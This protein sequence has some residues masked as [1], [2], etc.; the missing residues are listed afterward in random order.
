MRN[1]SELQAGSMLVDN[2]TLQNLCTQST[3][4]MFHELE[5]LTTP[6]TL[7][8]K[9]INK[10]TK[11]WKATLRVQA[12]VCY[13]RY[14][15]KPLTLVYQYLHLSSMSEL[16]RGRN[17]VTVDVRREEAF[18]NTTFGWK[19]ELNANEHPAAWQMKN[20]QRFFLFTVDTSAAVLLFHFI[21]SESAPQN[22]SLQKQHFVFTNHMLSKRENIF[23]IWRTMSVYKKIKGTSLQNR[24]H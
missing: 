2:S 6:L 22:M 12:S 18:I 13:D 23:H 11:T 16:W 21:V 7:V 15:P 14:Y 1:T 19:E 17:S 3:K 20:I 5:S 4:K 10:K 8:S 24:L 9:S